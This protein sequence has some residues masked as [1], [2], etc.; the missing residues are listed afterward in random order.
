MAYLDIPNTFSPNGDGINDEYRVN[1]EYIKSFEAII[2]DRNQNVMYRW[3]NINEAWDGKDLRGN[4]V[5]KGVYFY[6]IKAIDMDGNMMKTK[7]GSVTIF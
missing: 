3:N 5:P 6:V 2:M 7:T 4:Q 1:G